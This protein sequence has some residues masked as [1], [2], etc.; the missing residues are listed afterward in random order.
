MIKEDNNMF[1]L[2]K[3]YTHKKMLDCAIL[4]LKTFKL[5]TAD[6]TIK[7]K[8]INKRGMDLGLVENVRITKDQVKNWYEL[9]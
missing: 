6:Y 9:N 3:T 8:W 2:N 7:I 1:K 4:I 5:Q